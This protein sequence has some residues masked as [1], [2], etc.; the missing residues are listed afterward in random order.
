M[1]TAV[2]SVVEKNAVL[3]KPLTYPDPQASVQL[4]TTSDQGPVP[5]ASIPEFNIWQEQRSIFQQ[6]GRL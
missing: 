1:N 6:S 4:V 2:F 3:W 5:V